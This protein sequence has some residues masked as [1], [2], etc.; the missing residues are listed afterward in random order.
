M[1]ERPST[2]IRE[3]FCSKF[4]HGNNRPS[5]YAQVVN[6]YFK[7]CRLAHQTPCRKV[8]PGN[9]VA[10]EHVKAAT[11]T[12]LTWNPPFLRP[13]DLERPWCTET[14][15]H[16][17]LSRDCSPCP[18][19]LKDHATTYLA[20]IH[21]ETA[22]IEAL[23]TEMLGYGHSPPTF[24]NGSLVLCWAPTT[25]L[26][27]PSAG[28]ATTINDYDSCQLLLL[29]LDIC[30]SYAYCATIH[31]FHLSA[32]SVSNIVRFLREML[33]NNINLRIDKSCFLSLV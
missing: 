29:T 33:L 17:K 13:A 31:F 32:R 5:V 22:N 4:S 8:I 11:T 27:H 18:L 28:T 24:S 3:L 21:G 30:W 1:K 9:N 7:P 23:V 15:R 19:T 2:K 12:T 6:L 14:D 20:T 10:N 25:R 26:G 16:L